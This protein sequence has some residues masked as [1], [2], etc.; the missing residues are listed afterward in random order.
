MNTLTK[1]RVRKTD[2]M[3]SGV[4][5]RIVR[6][7]RRLKKYERIL[8]RKQERAIKMLEREAYGWASLDQQ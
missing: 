8:Q 7:F 4:E 6:G 1:G 3:L 5:K 2:R